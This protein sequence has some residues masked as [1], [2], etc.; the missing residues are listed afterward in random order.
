MIRFALVLSILTMAGLTYVYEEVEAVK[1]GYMIRK[2]EESKV[3]LLDRGRALKYNIAHLK[4]PANLER[5]LASRQIVLGAPKAWQ[6]VILP[7]TSPRSMPAPAL[8]SKFFVGTAQAEAKEPR[9]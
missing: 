5:R 3:L 2:Q 8:L 4:A 7:G 9:R 1:T 6:T